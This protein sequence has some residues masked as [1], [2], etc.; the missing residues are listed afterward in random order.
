MLI[1][2]FL[3]N[4]PDIVTEEPP[5]ITLDSKYDLCMD[6][7]FK[8]TKHTRHISK[9]VNFVRNGEKSKMN[10]INCYEGGLQLEDITTKNVGDIDFK[11][12][13]EYT[14]ISIDNWYR[15]LVQE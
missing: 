15:T 9:R 2:E 7:N 1:H 3:N 4:Y 6:K 14:M 13:M 8:V 5:L 12:R 10:K 11:T